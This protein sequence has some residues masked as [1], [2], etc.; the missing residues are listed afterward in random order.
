MK[1]KI[2]ILIS[3]LLISCSKTRTNEKLIGNWHTN[4]TSSNLVTF[5]FYPDSLIHFDNQRGYYSAKWKIKNDKILLTHINGSMN[6]LSSTEFDFKLFKDGNELLLSNGKT[7]F[8]ALIRS[9]NAYDYFSQKIDMTISLPETDEDLYS[10]GFPYRN[11]NI[12][13]GFRNNK[14]IAKTDKSSNLSNLQKELRNFIKNN[15]DN[16]GQIHPLSQFSVFADQKTSK[17]KLDS[18]IEILE[19]SASI[20]IFQVLK[21]E[22]GD[23]QNDLNWKGYRLEN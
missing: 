22:N 9:E 2:L 21:N 11:F 18:I 17:V 3:F 14:L 20:P 6:H 4:L 13:V 15:S 23:Y 1:A 10:A 7:D 12:Y 8:P 16:K 5:K 19:N